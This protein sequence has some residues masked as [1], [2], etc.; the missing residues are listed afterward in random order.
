MPASWALCACVTVATQAVAQD[1][2]EAIRNLESA[3]MR[4]H[5]AA[6]E[7]AMA[8]RSLQRGNGQACLRHAERAEQFALHGTATELDRRERHRWPD[9]RRESPVVGP[10]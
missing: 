9:R 2:S 6:Q 7:F 10:R 5:A 8:E 4:T 1:C 3:P